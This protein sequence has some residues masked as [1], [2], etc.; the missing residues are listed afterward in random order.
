MNPRPPSKWRNPVMWLVVGLPGI[1]VVAGIGM[2]VVASRGG[3][4]DAIP[5]SVRRTAQVQVA[6]RELPALGRHDRVAHLA[7]R[8]GRD[9]HRELAGHRFP[10]GR[11]IAFKAG[12]VEAGGRRQ[13]P[14]GDDRAA[15][16]DRRSG[17]PSFE[18][19]DVAD[20]LAR[21]GVARAASCGTS[22]E[23]C[24]ELPSWN[25]ASSVVENGSAQLP[26]AL[27]GP[28]QPSARSTLR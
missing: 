28:T 14:I 27:R 9:G 24:Q 25:P 17:Q 22:H 10:A 11:E 16:A 20:L 4:N 26:S 1:A 8:V 2:I 12:S 7:P 6:E 19:A 15:A 5:E 21:D 23:Y 13:R 18:P 3:S